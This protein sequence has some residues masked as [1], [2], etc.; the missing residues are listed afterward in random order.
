MPFMSHDKP[1]ERKTGRVQSCSAR[2][3]LRGA[4]TAISPHRG[5]SRKAVG[6]RTFGKSEKSRPT[7][8]IV[9]F[10]TRF[11]LLF[12]RTLILSLWQKRPRGGKETRTHPRQGHPGPKILRQAR[13]S[14]GSGQKGAFYFS[15]IYRRSLLRNIAILPKVECP[16][17]L[18][19]GSFPRRKRRHSARGPCRCHGQGDPRRHHARHPR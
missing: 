18:V 3:L 19:F 15:M 14:P 5:R 11:A 17:W 6:V 16:L 9:I 10:G 1:E 8:K 12:K 7:G 2:L 4:G 13:A